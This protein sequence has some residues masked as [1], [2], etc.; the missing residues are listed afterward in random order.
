[1]FFDWHIFAD[2]EGELK[3]FISSCIFEYG[4]YAM[5]LAFALG[6]FSQ[7]FVIGKYLIPE[8]HFYARRRK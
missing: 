6:A 1:M 5:H 2:A 8:E 7:Q 4:V 3:I